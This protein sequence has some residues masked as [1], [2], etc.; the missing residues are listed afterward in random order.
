MQANLLGLSL[1]ARSGR[2]QPLRLRDGR[3]TVQDCGCLSASSSSSMIRSSI[4]LTQVAEFSTSSSST[5]TTKTT[6][7]RPENSNSEAG[8]G[9]IGGTDSDGG[10]IGE[11]DSISFTEAKRLL[12]LVNVEALKMKL[13][14]DGKEVI[15]YSELLEACESIGVARSIKEATAFARVLDEAGV[16]LLFRDK[17]YLH[18]DKVLPLI[19]FVSFSSFLKYALL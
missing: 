17:V 11:G 8:G 16:V 9:G 6:D 15:G 18:P 4:Y 14:M 19:T 5:T 3:R 2:K 13:G 10:V 12:R 1:D 7:P